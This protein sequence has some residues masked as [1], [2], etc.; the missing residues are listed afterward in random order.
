M[1]KLLIFLYTVFLLFGFIGSAS[2]AFLSGVN[3]SSG[4]SDV[5]Q[6]SYGNLCWAAS[7]SNMLAYGGWDGG[8]ALDTADE[9]FNY[10][11][12]HWTNEVG[13]PYYAVEW[14]GDGVNG[15]QGESG[16]AQVTTAGGDF[17]PSNSPL[18]GYGFSEDLPTIN[19]NLTSWI[20]DNVNSGSIGTVLLGSS[21]G[22]VHWLTY[23]G[24]DTISGDFGIWVT[25]S[26]SAANE[27]VWKG[28][29]QSG[30]NWYLDGYASVGYVISAARLDPNALDI[31][32]NNPDNGDNGENG[33]T[34][35]PEPA[36]LLLLVSGLLGL[37][38][39]RGRFRIS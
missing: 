14:W 24:Y 10:F 8:T 12:S 36:T 13:N 32:P 37:G 27:M 6:G 21:S 31:A 25:D 33:E 7:A 2:A 38:L 29:S 19:A 17:Y 34:T 35:V 3:A 1:K 23:W 5:S 39:M 4:W 11:S 9:I 18:G 16:W 28:L 26:F 15:K 22:G 20:T 30:G